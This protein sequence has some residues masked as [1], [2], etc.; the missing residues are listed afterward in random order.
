LS[1]ISATRSGASPAEGSS[2][3]RRSGS[4]M[5]AAPD[6][7]AEMFDKVDEINAAGTAVLMV[8]Q[9]AKEALRRCDRGYVLVNGENAFEGPGTELLANDEVRQRFLGG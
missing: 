5:S 1:N 3:R 4:S 6:L 7:V 8:E 9:N 2:N